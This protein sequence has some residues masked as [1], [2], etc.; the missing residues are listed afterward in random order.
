MNF[1][2][3]YKNIMFCVRKRRHF[4]DAQKTQSPS[5]VSFRHTKQGLPETFLLGTQNMSEI[6]YEH[7]RF[8]HEQF[9]ELF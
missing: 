8:I 9:Y 1:F 5:D 2:K 7:N 6:N 3:L 4:F